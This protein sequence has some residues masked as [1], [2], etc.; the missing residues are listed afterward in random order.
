MTG[1]EGPRGLRPF[2]PNALAGEEPSR[3]GA[4]GAAGAVYRFWSSEF[5]GCGVP[6]FGNGKLP[7]VKMPLVCVR[8][9][10]GDSTIGEK[11]DSAPLGN[12]ECCAGICVCS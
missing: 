4:R 10:A 7:G 9:D 12:G 2:A 11:Y 8:L 6:V 5:Q 3:E 1:I